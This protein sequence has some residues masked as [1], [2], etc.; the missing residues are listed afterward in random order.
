MKRPGAVL[1]PELLACLAEQQAPAAP[2]PE[3]AARLKVRIM[4]EVRAGAATQP[5]VAPPTLTVRAMEGQWVPLGPRMEMKVLR[6]DAE[7]RSFLLRLQ[8]GAVLPPHDHP[9]D[10]ECYVLEGEVSFGDVRIGAGDYHL[11]PRGVPHGL[12][13]SRRGAL[14]L[15]RGASPGDER[16]VT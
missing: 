3:V 10:E 13:R 9:L 7:S 14:L 4:E 1:D 16:R 15:L 2:R 11:A 5:A 8:P 12:V 6:Q